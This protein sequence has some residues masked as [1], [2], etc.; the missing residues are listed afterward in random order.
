MKDRKASKYHSRSSRV[1][2]PVHIN[3]KGVIDYKLPLCDL[4]YSILSKKSFNTSVITETLDGNQYYYDYD[5]DG[6]NIIVSKSQIIKDSP[7]LKLIE[8]Y[9]GNYLGKELYNDSIVLVLYKDDKKVTETI[10]YKKDLGLNVDMVIEVGSYFYKLPLCEF[11]DNIIR[12]TPDILKFIYFGFEGDM[13]Y[14]TLE[15]DGKDINYI[16]YSVNNSKLD[17]IEKAIGNRLVKEFS[18]HNNIILSLYDDNTRVKDIVA[19]SSK[20]LY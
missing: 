10:S 8:R 15:F 7:G 9:K 1:F 11:M 4:M 20:F 19:Y 12:K 17:E 3:S 18:G 14:I 6:K 13:Y 16:K 2:A 5:F